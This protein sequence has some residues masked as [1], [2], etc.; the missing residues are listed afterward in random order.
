MC[1]DWCLLKF[2]FSINS[3]LRARGNGKIGSYSF[4]T[5]FLS[6]QRTK[7]PNPKQSTKIYIYIF[8]R[9]EH[10]CLKWFIIFF[11]FYIHN[12]SA[13]WF[14]LRLRCDFLTIKCEQRIIY[15]SH[16]LQITI[17]PDTCVAEKGNWKFFKVSLTAEEQNRFQNGFNDVVWHICA[18]IFF[19]SSYWWLFIQ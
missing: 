10:N 12:H 17:A 8:P 14:W 1:D 11:S 18:S 7:S 6:M 3:N 5:K 16:P 15:P 19:E 9:I 2:G 4:S 13:K